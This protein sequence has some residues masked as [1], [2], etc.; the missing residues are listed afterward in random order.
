VRSN[1]GIDMNQRGLLLRL[2]YSIGRDASG[3]DDNLRGE[4]LASTSEDPSCQYSSNIA[5]SNRVDS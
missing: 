4:S 5:T 2:L 1:L 3:W